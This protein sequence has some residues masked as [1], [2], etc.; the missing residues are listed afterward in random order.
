VRRNL[1]TRSGSPPSLGAPIE[2]LVRLIRGRHK[3]DILICLHPGPQ[4]FSA[5]HRAIPGVSERV[6]SRQLDE[7]KRDGLVHRTVYPEAP[8]RVEYD[9]TQFGRTLCPLLKQMW[10]WGVEHADGAAP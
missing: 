10:K 4:R 5:L 8:P 3:P 7:L 6:L 9:L 2:A 1:S